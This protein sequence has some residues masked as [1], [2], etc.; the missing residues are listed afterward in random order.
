MNSMA[1]RTN[2]TY[3]PDHNKIQVV[4]QGTLLGVLVPTKSSKKLF[5]KTSDGLKFDRKS[6]AAKYL[7]DR[8]QG[9]YD[10]VTVLSTRVLH[11]FPEAPL[12]EEVMLIPPKV[13]LPSKEGIFIGI[14]P[15][16][17]NMGLTVFDRSI[18]QAICYEVRFSQEVNHVL[19]INRVYSLTLKLIQDALTTLGYDEDTTSLTWAVVEGAS[20]GSPFGQVDLSEA[21]TAALLAL[22]SE[23]ITIVAPKSIRATVFGNASVR[24]EELWSQLP[25][26]A[27]SS[28]ACA[29]CATKVVH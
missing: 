12:V 11:Q 10:K 18:G 6:G 26:D 23:H 8:E 1:K 28:L 17:A 27:A 24:A 5:W 13:F 2:F 7:L 25:P 29:L 16:S 22:S 14:D 20:F 15:G 3:I 4:F 9:K 21:R 19:K